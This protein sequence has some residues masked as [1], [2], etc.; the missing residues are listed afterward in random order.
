MTCSWTCVCASS[1][2]FSLSWEFLGL[3]LTSSVSFSDGW[4]RLRDTRLS[5]AHTHTRPS[6][7]IV[8]AHTAQR[9]AA[10]EKNRTLSRSSIQWRL[11]SREALLFSSLLFSLLSSH[12]LHDSSD[13]SDQSLIITLV[14]WKRSTGD[15][16]THNI[17]KRRRRRRR[18]MKEWK[19]KLNK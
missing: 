2:S 19:K 4:L 3:C 7:L 18:R 10:I 8:S 6:L 1:Y 12:N 15:A 11:L 14:A 13:C 9:S 5:Y 17:K 16:H